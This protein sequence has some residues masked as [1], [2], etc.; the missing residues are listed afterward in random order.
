MAY[1]L[2]HVLEQRAPHDRKDHM[3]AGTEDRSLDGIGILQEMPA[4]ALA[5]LADKCGWKVYAAQQQ[6]IG[7]QDESRN[8]FFLVR[9][10]VRA[11]IYSLSGKEV[12]FRDIEQGG[13]FGEFA[14]IDEEPRSASVEALTPCL[15]ATMP[16][17]LFWD[18]LQVNPTVMAAMLR[19]LTGQIRI[20]TERVLEFSTLAVRNRIHAELLRLAQHHLMDDGTAEITPAP[21]HVELANRISTHREAVT[22]EMV[23]LAHADL[24]ERRHGTLV[25]RDVPRLTRMVQEVLGN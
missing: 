8:A 20:L 3:T 16:S 12:I 6:I 14:A 24:V 9:G 2:E 22:R 21:T 4:E 10:Q 11:S 15:I 7:Y 19:R 17:E 5:A 13:I 23:R 18:V 25:I 1:L